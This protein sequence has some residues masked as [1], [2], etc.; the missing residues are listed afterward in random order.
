VEDPET[1]GVLQFSPNPASSLIRIDPSSG[2][3]ALEFID[4]TGR[5]IQL[6]ANRGQVDVSG[7]TPGVYGVRT[8]GNRIGTVRA[9]RILIVR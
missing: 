7:L 9:G 6:R 4:A 8:L 2:V 5:A 1:S 3:E